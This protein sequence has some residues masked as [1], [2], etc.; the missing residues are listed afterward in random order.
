MLFDFPLFPAKF[1]IPDAWW[2]EAGMPGFRLS[3]ESYV[4]DGLCATVA[5]V[6]IEPP[7]RLHQSPLDFQGFSRARLIS[8]LSGFVADDKI[9]PVRLIDL[10]SLGN[11]P[12][13]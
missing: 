8:I 11:P 2:E 4:P 12:C 6:T 13:N 10:P 9:E 7:F 1:E 3:A 5:L